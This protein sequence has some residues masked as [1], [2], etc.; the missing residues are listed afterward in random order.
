[1]LAWVTRETGREVVFA[2]PAVHA[3]LGGE[4]ITGELLV[5]P[6]AALEIVPRL[7]GLVGRVDG[8]TLFLAAVNGR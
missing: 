7:Y 3:R 1:M 5:G 8:G 2:D 6:L 4:R